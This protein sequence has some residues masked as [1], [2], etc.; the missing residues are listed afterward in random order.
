MA[1]R[2]IDSIQVQVVGVHDD[3]A[4]EIPVAVIKLSNEMANHQDVLWRLREVAAKELGLTEQPFAY[5]TLDDLGLTSFP[6]TLS[7]KIKKGKLSEIVQEHLKNRT[8]HSSPITGNVSTAD[9]LVQLWATVSGVT[10]S[11]IDPKASVFTFADSITMMRLSSSV[12][13]QLHK[14]LSVDD[15]TKHPSIDEQA[16]LLDG[17]QVRTS[18]EPLTA[19]LGPPTTSEMAHCQES[20]AKA[21]DTKKVALD[22]LRKL[23]LS[24]SDDVEDVFPAP[25]TSY[26]YLNRQRPQTWNQRVIYLAPKVNVE[27]L[28]RAWE[29]V[30]VHH[31]MFR[32]VA[33]PVKPELA[34]GSHLFVVLRP[35]PNFWNCSIVT[36]LEVET[37]EDL[38]GAF[39]NEWADT[40]SGPLVRVAFASIKNPESSAFI[41]VGNHAA[42]DNLS[43]DLLIE[44]LKT[45]LEHKLTKNNILYAPGH[46]PFKRFAD[47][48]FTYRSS[49]EAMEAAT[50]HANRLRGIGNAKD[51]LWPKPRAPGFFKGQDDGWTHPDGTPGDALLRTPLDPPH[52]R[53]GL[54]GLTRTAPVNTLRAMKEQYGI[55]PH[56]ILKVA[57]ALF[58][59][60]Q[61]GTYTA[62]F[63]NVEAG[64]KWPS[65]STEEDLPNPLGIAGPMF[66]V[67]L[68]RI[69]VQGQMEKVLDVLKRAQDEQ[70]LLT[71]H[72][73]APLF[74][75]ASSLPSSDKEV[76]FDALARQGYNWAPGIQS[77]PKSSEKAKEETLY[78]FNRQALDDIGLAWTCG[79]W[80]PETFYVNG[81]YD[82]CQL[83]KEEVNVFVGQVLA[84][85]VWLADPQNAQRRVD[86]CVFDAKN[87]RVSGLIQSLE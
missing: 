28:T 1:R 19:R 59:M 34:G 20:D 38:R 7:G 39:L 53:H 57:V 67:V 51:S 9:D 17:R 5:L 79:L 48:Y 30:L 22:M 72:S 77:G 74:K 44:D 18:I 21:A 64:R 42:Y 50:F 43:M 86:E 54:D 13:K 45:A 6:Y 55:M 83:G 11:T 4:G 60:R 49:E 56:V 14:D 40:L 63:A 62:M 65:S 52:D 69:T 41:L 36:G 76:F 29:A 81:S 87:A 37:P 84:A 2:L 25:D 33:I 16:V 75:I 66:Q 10:A 61:T 68:N 24:W 35:S 3:V 8:T 27:A 47:S 32:T 15:I 73:Q 85:G 70:A 12:K 71:Q 58:N 26:I 46:V 23:S 82:D 80:N 31:S 78:K